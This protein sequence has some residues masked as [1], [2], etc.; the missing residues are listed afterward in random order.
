M[1]NKSNTLVIH[2]K[3]DST[4]ML[5]NVYEGKGFDVI[6]DP[7]V[8]RA[9]LID[10]I[11]SHQRIIFLGHGTPGGLIHPCMLKMHSMPIGGIKY[12]VDDSIAPYLRGKDT[13][14]MWCFSNEY[15]QRN[16]LPGFHTGMIISERREALMML[17]KC[18][19]TDGQLF[20]SMV[21]LAKLLGE[22]LDEPPVVMR[23]YILNHYIG[24][25]AITQFNRENFTIVN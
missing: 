18:P 5:K 1:V 20:D 23:E 3:D 7:D 21:H 16:H 13:I 19:L 8:S 2:P 6:D 12:I 10:A 14:S 25:D 4:V 22:C 11:K 17:G 24:N 9:E 15:F